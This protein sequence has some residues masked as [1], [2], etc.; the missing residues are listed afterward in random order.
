MN[1]N[2][3]RLQELILKDRISELNKKS[4]E[5]ELFYLECNSEDCAYVL[6]VYDQLKSTNQKTSNPNNSTIMYLLGLTD[7]EPHGIISKTPISLP[8]IDYDTDARDEIK[9]YLVKKYGED[10]VSLLGTYNTLKVKG[11]IKDVVRRV[12]PEMNFDEVNAI[13]KKFD[14]IKRTDTDQMKEILVGKGD[15]YSFITDYAS[16]L[17]FFYSTQEVDRD[18]KNWFENNIEVKEAVIQLLGNA[19]STGIHAG[20]IVVSSA[21]IKTV[22]PLTY[23]RDEHVWVTQPEMGHVEGAGLIKYDFLGLNTLGDLNRCLKL[24]NKRHGTKYTLSNIPLKDESVLDEFQKGNVKSVFQFDT[25][26]VQPNLMKM[27]EIKSINDLAMITSIWRPGPLNMGMD[28]IFIN[29]K[30]GDEPI[31]Y[32][33]MSLE[34]L[35]K[36][37]YGIIIYQED[38]LKVVQQIGGLTGDESVTVLKAMGK[39]Q[40][41]KLVKY[42]EKFKKNGVKNFPSFSAIIE[43]EDFETKEKKKLKKIDALWSLLYSFSSYGFNKSHA[44]AYACV[45]YLCMWFKKYYTVEWISAV[46]DGSD[47]EDFKSM[48]QKWSSYIL[49]PDVNESKG[50]Y[51]ISSDSKH[52]VMPFSAVN[53]VGDKAVD[54][55]VAAQPFTSFAD[56]YERVEKRKVNKKVFIN[57]IFSGCFD[58]FKA[59]ELTVSKYRKALIHEFIVLRH[60]EKKPGKLDK[61]Q[62]DALLE[63]MDGLTRGKI[64]MKEIDLLNFTS[65]D[66]HEFFKEKMTTESKRLLGS[67]ASRPSEVLHLKDKTQV[68]IGGAIQSIVFTPIK[69]GKNMGKEMA[70]LMLSN[71]GVTIRITIFPRQL[72]QDDKAGGELRKLQEGTPMI[73]KGNVNIWND[74]F[75]VIYETGVIL[76]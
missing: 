24:V 67:V 62:D 17:A 25:N 42:E 26:L 32:L 3:K 73:I 22:V 39:K 20:G 13:T 41:D 27:K 58:C 36:D 55:I 54:S 48:Y 47:K 61:E 52:V 9:N 40:A 1:N 23:E 30:N 5:Q 2:F 70:I 29:R 14:L 6:K 45:S 12:R 69:T 43:Y 4:Y 37:T 28:K 56:F 34:P 76:A 49:R 16:E 46:L 68:V 63:E 15:Q 60:K 57:L 64:L 19:K 75:G 8:D 72:E 65:F 18:L 21:D 35:L 10:H 7:V 51:Y 33:D 44:I 53:G 66:Y 74:N 11:A 59:P 50:S 71:E 31:S 38:V